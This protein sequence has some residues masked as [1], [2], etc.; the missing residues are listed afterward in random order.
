MPRHNFECGKCAAPNT[1]DVSPQCGCH[2]CEARR[3]ATNHYRMLI[4]LVRAVA[5]VS[6]IGLTMIPTGCLING[7][8]ENQKFEATKRIDYEATAAKMKVDAEV[9]IKKSEVRIKEIEA[10]KGLN[11]DK[12]EVKSTI[13]GDG[14]VAVILIPKE[15]Q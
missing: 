14:K 6:A 1:V 11:L 3:P 15:K 5:I 12:F 8:F 9:E 4:N 13:T 7:H 10:M 2:E